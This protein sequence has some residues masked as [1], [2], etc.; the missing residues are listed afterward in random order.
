MKFIKSYLDL[1]VYNLSFKLAMSIFNLTKTFPKEEK[2]SLVDQMLR[3]SRSVSANVSEAFRARRYKKSFISKLVIAQCEASETQ[4]W[5]DF[6]N[7]CKYI[8]ETEYKEMHNE[9]EHVLAMILN[10]IK[11]VDKWTID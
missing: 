7:A 10:M 4:T 9:Y 2:Y 8:D 5:L 1:D 3:S 11:N 6:A